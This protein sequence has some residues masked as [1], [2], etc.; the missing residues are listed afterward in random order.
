MDFEVVC[1]VA[2]NDS[3]ARHH[4][5]PIAQHPLVTRL[6]IVRHKKIGPGQI[7]KAEYVLVPTRFK[8][9]R[10]VQMMWICLRLG[11]KEQ[12]GA[13]VSFNSIPYGLF[14]TNNQRTRI[15]NGGNYL[16]VRKSAFA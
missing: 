6:W 12:V 13:F 7:P 9:W 11:R 10:F 15:V 5:M 14:S 1:C 2:L 8:L 4:F 3:M 16:I